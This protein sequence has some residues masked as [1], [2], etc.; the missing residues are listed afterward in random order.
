MV[1]GFPPPDLG[2]LV[3]ASLAICTTVCALAMEAAVIFTPAFLFV[4]PAVISGFP[5]LTVNEAI[6]LAL[7]VEFFGYTS[8]V[9]GYWFR[10]QIDFTVALRL[11]AIT[12]P[13][14][15]L[16]RLVSYAVPSRALLVLFGVMLVGLSVVLHQEHAEGAPLHSR[17]LDASPLANRWVET[18]SV[19]PG[20]YV[21]RSRFRHEDGEG[22]D[23][24][25][26]DRGIVAVGG[27][28]AGLVGIAVGEVTSTLLSVRKRL[29]IQLTTGTAA[30]V[31][32]VTILAA[33]VVNLGVL[34]VAP[35]FAG[36]GASVPLAVGGVIA[37]VV[38][39]GGQVGSYI[40][41]RL[42][43]ETTL[44]VLVVA[45][46]LVGLFV[47]LKTLVLGGGAH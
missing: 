6:G 37:P 26:S 12:V 31:L 24:D 47:V 32:H 20:E 15:V 23:L 17:V 11:L 21:P 13:V 46:F 14:A 7:F 44:R 8:S 35:G 16:F 34:R 3:A 42:A 18:S 29:P 25:R 45:Y 41:S 5:Q 1:L 43:E 30:L 27:A 39:V 28:L 22:F 2:L 38:V 33:L 36:E 19:I 10:H 9:T 40:N 4:F